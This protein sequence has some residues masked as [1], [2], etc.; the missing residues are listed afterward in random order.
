MDTA[1]FDK[2]AQVCSKD[3][4]NEIDKI[5]SD[6]KGKKVCAIGFITTDDFYGFYLTWDCSNNI[7]E[8]YEWEK[9]LNPSF[10]YQPVVDIV[11][12]C[13]DIDFCNPSDEKWEFA[14]TLLSVLEKS[15]KQ[16]SEDIFQKS[17]FKRE[18]I[19]FFSTMSDGDYI[20]EMMDTSVKMFNTPETLET[21]GL[22][23]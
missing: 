3:L 2:F 17:G 20:Q 5:L 13:D 14:Q 12:T 23:S 7:N 15:I 1:I 16:I 19:L 11:E 9:S 22:I 4:P 10:L 21:Y 8:Y 6:A 18:D